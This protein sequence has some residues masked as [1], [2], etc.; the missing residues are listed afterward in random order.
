[1]GGSKVESRHRVTPQ[2]APPFPTRLQRRIGL[3]GGIAT[4]KSSV[5]R[6]LKERYGLPVLD[7]DAYAHEA[8]APGT[9]ATLAVLAH[10]GPRVRMG[11]T[12]PGT[13]DAPDPA[14][15]TIDRAALGR[16][17]FADAEERRW[18]ERL[19]HP[20]VRARFGQE[21]ERVAAAPVVVL[22]VPLLFEAGLESLCSEVW[23]VTCD[24]A[25]QHQRLQARDHLNALEAEERI[26]S[27]WPLKHKQALADVCIDN[28]QGPGD[29]EAAVAAAL[30][31][32]PPPPRQ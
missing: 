29:L 19:L 1:M 10:F 18:L 16:I 6:L 27:Q 8:L 28:R 20:L 11:A 13:G 14:A 32:P 24:P 12:S 30:E 4:G 2:M 7:A 31:G 21:L 25:Q 9:A 17:V 23:V 15:A 3:T 22:M 5:A 26:T